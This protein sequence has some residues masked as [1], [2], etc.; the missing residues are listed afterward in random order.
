MGMETGSCHGFLEGIGREQIEQ[1]HQFIF[2]SIRLQNGQA[3]CTGRSVLHVFEQLFFPF[4][5]NLKISDFIV[6]PFT[7][8]V[9][10]QMA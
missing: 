3:C 4:I 6:G 8:V 5:Y 1:W 9:V 2:S 10:L 7:M